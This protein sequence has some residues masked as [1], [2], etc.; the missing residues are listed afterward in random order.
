MKKFM[1]DKEKAN[2]VL[3]Y[4]PTLVKKL[5]HFFYGDMCDTDI[6]D[7]HV[8]MEE[9]KEYLSN[10]LRNLPLPLYA[11]IGMLVRANNGIIEFKHPYTYRMGTL[12]IVSVEYDDTYGTFVRFTNTD[13]VYL[14]QDF[15][16]EEVRG[17]YDHIFNDIERKRVG[18]IKPSSETDKLKMAY[19][20]AIKQ[21]LENEPL[22]QLVFD[23]D[24]TLDL[25]LWKDTVTHE[26]IRIYISREDNEVCIA[27]SVNEAEG[28]TADPLSYFGYDEVKA[29]F[30]IFI[31][32]LYSNEEE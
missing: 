20:K 10:M 6:S 12:P 23:N 25:F 26:L 15:L 18:Q 4:V 28:I 32:Q 3:N 14:D 30:D 21:H 17:L 29:I 2:E 8:D 24:T 19:I 27:T 9:T 22:Q 11:L 13:F 5:M 31:T 1:I 16:D 7:S